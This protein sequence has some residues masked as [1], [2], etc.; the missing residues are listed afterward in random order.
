MGGKP[1]GELFGF[2]AG[3]KYSGPDSEGEGA[4]GGGSA[5]VLELVLIH[6]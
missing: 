1:G 5:D 6:I 4:E 3:D 2:G